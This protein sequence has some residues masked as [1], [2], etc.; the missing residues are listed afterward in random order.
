[1][2]RPASISLGLDRLRKK[3]EKN[4]VTRSAWPEEYTHKK[5][6]KP[7]RPHNEEERQFVYDDAPRNLLLKGGEGG[8]KSVAGIVKTLGRLRRGM[9]GIMVSPDFEHFKKSLWPE[10]VNWCPV[11]QVIPRH[12]Y[13]FETGWEP[14]RP[15]TLVF[16]N[17]VDGYSFLICG[18]IENPSSYEGPNISFVHFD[19]ARRHRTPEAIKVLTGRIRISG[20]KGEP[21]QIY[22][23][24][25]PRKHW[26]FDYFGPIKDNDPLSAFKRNS[27]VATVLTEENKDN[28]EEGF[29]EKRAEGLTEAETRV[30][31]GA[32]WEDETDVEKFV[33]IIWWD[34]NSE[35]LPPL[36]RSEPM[37]LA[38]DAATG[39]ESS[40]LADGFAVVGVT[41]HPHRKQDVAV[42]YCGIWQ[43][44]PGQLL[45]YE[46]IKQEI[47]RLCREFS[48]IEVTFDPTQLHDMTQTMKRDGVALFKKFNQGQ[49]RLVADKDLQNLI[50]SKRVAHDGNPLLRQHID[51]AYVKK[52]GQN[53]VRIVKRTGSL[54]IDAAV[55]LA[56]S[57]NRC[58]YYNLT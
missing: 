36:T 28:L 38:L 25:T 42:R 47:R 39:G 51:N 21:S 52:Y 27:F 23:T 13:R 49:E 6:G 46:P 19:E 45:D 55:A 8:G 35:S 18:G 10:F 29:A 32:Q 41:R 24:S 26:L 3:A 9:S 12:R 48:V 57:A 16:Y 15:F 31:L 34:N 11:E 56:M 58:L 2:S 4:R 20:P 40:T 22:L 53:G 44:Q 7:Y 54:K 17:E 37:V 14:G 43:P 33:Q 1:M 50:A 5:T 30:V